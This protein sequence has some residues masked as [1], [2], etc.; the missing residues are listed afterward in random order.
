MTLPMP[1]ELIE[2][3]MRTQI[4]TT[5]PQVLWFKF[6]ISNRMEAITEKIKI[7][8]TERECFVSDRT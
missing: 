1:I 5:L 2:Y 7:S 3:L 4:L 6:F 8:E